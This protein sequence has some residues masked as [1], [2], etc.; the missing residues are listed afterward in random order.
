M[1]VLWFCRG[2]VW[3]RGLG[4]VRF[5]SRWAWVVRFTTSPIYKFAYQVAETGVGNS[6]RV[7]VLAFGYLLLCAVSWFLSV[8]WWVIGSPYLRIFLCM[9]LRCRA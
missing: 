8:S 6:V 3:F 5:I 7:L 4:G 1:F 2:W 9:S